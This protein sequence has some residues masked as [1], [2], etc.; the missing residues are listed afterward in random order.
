MAFLQTLP[1]WETTLYLLLGLSSYATAILVYRLWLSPLSCFPGSPFA[2]ATFLYEFYYDF[3]KPGLYY[4]KIQEMHQRYGPIIRVTPTELHVSDPAYYSSVFVPGNVGKS[5]LDAGA[6]NGTGFEGYIKR[7]RS[8]DEH[9]IVR[10]P[11]Q[12]FFST[13]GVRELETHVQSGIER[14]RD[15][16]D[17]FKDTN[18]PVNLTYALLSFAIDTVSTIICERPTNYLAD[19]DFNGAWHKDALRPS[20]KVTIGDTQRGKAVKQQFG[21]DIYDLA[22]QL[23]QQSAVFPLSLTVQTIVT[24]LS[25]DARARGSLQI[26]LKEHLSNNP[27]PILARNLEKLRYLDACIKE[28]LRMSSGSL[29]RTNRI[30]PT[31]SIQLGEWTIPRGTPIGMAS[32]TLHMDPEVY[33]N[34]HAFIPERWLEEE[35]KNTSVF[36]DGQHFV[37]FG[38]GSRDC[39]GRNL[40]H[41]IILRLLLEFYAPGAPELELFAT[42]GSDVVPVHGYIISLPSYQS[43]GVRALLHSAS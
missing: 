13:S 12:Q 37:P 35:R 19:P 26:E 16:L 39:I 29:K 1:M 11:I 43:K 18:V 7:V 34:P 6:S 14:L 15:R 32:H 33:P 27:G 40:A 8:H 5:E 28:G 31:I 21:D 24:H 25:L 36:G 4:Q 17:E 41:M 23:I 9:R 10:A 30:F 38:R 22:G 3:I 42:D 2:K 20:T